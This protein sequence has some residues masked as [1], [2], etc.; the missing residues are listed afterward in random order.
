MASCF[1]S[2]P[3]IAAFL[4]AYRFAS[5]LR[6]LLGE[7]SLTSSLIPHFEDL[8][9][10]SSAKGAEF[11]RDL[12]CSLVLLLAGLILLCKQLFAPWEAS[13]HILHLT[14]LMLPGMLF[15]C[16]F[17]LSSAVLQCE[18]RFF[19]SG[20]APV[21]FNGVWVV[22]A[23]CLRGVPV[24]DAMQTLC[25]AIVGGY[26]VQWLIT[27]PF[28]M[29]FLRRSL[30]MGQIWRIRPFSVEVRRLARPLMLN[31]VGIG[32]VQINSVLDALFAS[33][34]RTEGPAFLWY[35]IRIEQAPIALVGVALSS[36][37][38]PALARAMQ[39]G[40]TEQFYSQLRF[41]V[42]RG[43]YIMLPLS[44][45]L[46]A[47]G[48]SLVN[49]LYGR[50]AFDAHTTS[51]TLLCL[52]GYAVGLVASA[53]TLL[54]SQAFYAWHDYKTPAT[55]SL[56]A[57][58]VNLS[59][60]ALMVFVCHFGPMSIALATSLS[61]V[62]NAALL[63]RALSRRMGSPLVRPSD[64]QTAKLVLCS[65]TAALVTLGIGALLLGDPSW[66]IL[67]GRGTHPFVRGSLAQMGHFLLLASCFL[68]VFFLAARA[69]RARLPS[70]REEVADVG[71]VQGDGKEDLLER[72]GR[73]KLP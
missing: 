46:L 39:S 26:A 38:L 16:L 41:A 27:G 17:A 73:E 15:I 56:V 65:L 32:A 69:L 53:S 21:L 60:N 62:C 37:L 63:R 31:V 9:R 67:V 14:S 6:R 1:G 71:D 55:A 54:L 50:G 40:E 30:S 43:F 51:Q 12:F 52:W 45:A 24:H 66:R 47:V 36:A 33:W 49:F 70:M 7:A 29:R 4:V 11:L 28:Y 34:S 8:R 10:I 61:A 64:G 18:G 68:G 25:F 2:D 72:G 44:F 13:S 57:V 35:A 59:A 20:F 5:L 58:A 42:Q 23:F 3:A 48:G 19:L 22:A